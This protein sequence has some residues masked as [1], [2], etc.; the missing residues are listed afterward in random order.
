MFDHPVLL[1]GEFGDAVGVG[2]GDRVAFI[3]REIGGAAVELAGGG[4]DDDGVGGGLAGGLNEADLG[5]GVDGDVG[6]RVFL[7]AHVAGLGGEVE[8]DVGALAKRAEIDIADIGADQFD[9]G[10]V[11]IGRVGA[12]ANLTAVQSDHA[13]AALGQS[14]AEFGAEEACAACHQHSFARPIHV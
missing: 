9:I 5:D 6:Q 3:D 7:A 8:D 10:A 14:V 1:A 11:Q 4:V 2:R 12:A 13:G